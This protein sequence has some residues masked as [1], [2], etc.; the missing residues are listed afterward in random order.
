MAIN[1]ANLNISLDQFQ[2]MATGDYNAGEVALKSES[3]LTKI[4]NHV[5]RLSANTKSISHEEVLAI[6]NAS[7]AELGNGMP[8]FTIDDF[9]QVES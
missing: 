8:E 7:D 4:N 6:K 1:L 9:T 3:K 5:H 2:K